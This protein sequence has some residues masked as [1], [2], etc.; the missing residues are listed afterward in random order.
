TQVSQ[1][2]GEDMGNTDVPSVVNVDPKDRFKK[3]KRPPT[4]DPEWNECKSVDNKPT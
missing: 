1:N 4:P 2:L 3:P